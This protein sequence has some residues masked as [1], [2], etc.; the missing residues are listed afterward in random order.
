MLFVVVVVAIGLV[1]GFVRFAPLVLILILI[2][3]IAVVSIAPS[4]LIVGLIPSAW[5]T[6]VPR[7]AAAYLYVDL[8]MG[9]GCYPAHHQSDDN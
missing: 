5:M 2:V 3:H 8:C 1:V 7:F 9:W 6:L 4:P